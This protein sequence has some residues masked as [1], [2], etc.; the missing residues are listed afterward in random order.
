MYTIILLLLI[1]QPDTLI[2]HKFLFIF[3]KEGREVK[4]E[5]VWE[6]YSKGEWVVEDTLYQ[7]YHY[8]QYYDLIRKYEVRADMQVNYTD[9]ELLIG[10]ED[11]WV[12]YYIFDDSKS[13]EVK[14]LYVGETYIMTTE[15]H[16]YHFKNDDIVHFIS[17]WIDL[18]PIYF[19]IHEVS[20]DEPKVN[21]VYHS[22]TLGLPVFSPTIIDITEEG[23]FINYMDGQ[24]T[25][26]ARLYYDDYKQ[27]FILK[28]GYEP[29]IERR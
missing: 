24:E 13:L 9:G 28:E 21:L 1:A 29:Q 14:S 26:R 25:K 5:T 15:L 23:F 18:D 11:D 22:P 2:S 27:D 12:L 6:T 10:I 8:Y 16:E 3:E 20:K 19:L 17:V 4:H 7:Y